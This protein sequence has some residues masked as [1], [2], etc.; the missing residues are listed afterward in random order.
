M[1]QGLEKISL[2]IDSVTRQLADGALDDL[3][4][5][6]RYL[7]YRYGGTEQLEGPA[8]AKEIR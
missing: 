6:H 5:K 2:E 8:P 3:A 7:D 1:T 4:I